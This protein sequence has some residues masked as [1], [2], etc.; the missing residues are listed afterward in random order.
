M[1][2]ITSHLLVST[3]GDL[4]AERQCR[5]MKRTAQHSADDARSGLSKRTP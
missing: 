5:S 4:T 2:K 1:V 3:A